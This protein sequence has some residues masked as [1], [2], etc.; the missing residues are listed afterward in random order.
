MSPFFYENVP[1]SRCL[2]NGH[3]H[4]TYKIPQ[5]VQ[6]GEGIVGPPPDLDYSRMP[7][8]STFAIAAQ[9]SPTAFEPAD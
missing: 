8:A 5:D 9:P 7:D 1:Y 3:P 6:I 2:S 4:G